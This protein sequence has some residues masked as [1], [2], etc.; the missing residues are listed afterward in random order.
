MLDKTTLERQLEVVQR[1]FDDGKMEFSENATW[2]G[3][4]EGLKAKVTQYKDRKGNNCFDFEFLEQSYPYKDLTQILFTR[5]GG[6]KGISSGS[7][8]LLFFDE[9]GFKVL[10]DEHSD[11]SGRHWRTWTFTN[12]GIYAN[13]IK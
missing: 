5:G 3:R 8:G 1:M 7:I 13:R 2:I 12:I 9:E 4:I 6:D 11:L 10:Y